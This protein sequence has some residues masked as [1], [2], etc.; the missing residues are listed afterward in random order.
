MKKLCIVLAGLLL[1]APAL[2]APEFKTYEARNPVREGQGGER[3]T[4][5][6][7]DF[8]TN[9]D[10]PRRYQI[11]G[12]LTDERH[13]TGLWGMIRMSSYES[14]I[15][16][17]AK[18]AG[19]DAV[20]LV[21]ENDQVVGIVGGGFGDANATYNGNTA[22][23]SGSWFG[24]SRPMKEHDS[25]FLVIKYLPDATPAQPAPSQPSAQ[26]PAAPPVPPASQ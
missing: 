6:T 8:W 15:A 13:K 9:G 19:G 11:I 17:A 25:R 24:T 20:I 14:D 21:S 1:A 5:D 23:A 18:A 22:N 4:V 3:K 10:P 7:I 12:S 2:A 26:S 16:K